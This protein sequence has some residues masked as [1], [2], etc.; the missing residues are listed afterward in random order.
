MRT[1]RRVVGL[2]LL[3]LCVTA[4]VVSLGAALEAP[5]RLRC[6]NGARPEKLV[7]VAAVGV[8][9]GMLHVLST[10]APEALAV[11]TFDRQPTTQ[12]L[13]TAAWQA[14]LSRLERPAPAPASVRK[15]E[16]AINVELTCD[17]QTLPKRTGAWAQGAQHPDLESVV[18][19]P[20]WWAL[21]GFVSGTL[22]DLDP[23]PRRALALLTELLRLEHPELWRD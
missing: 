15:W 16:G 3:V 17:G 4:G 12:P 22:A 1:R 13:D 10:I 23:R 9:H 18:R 20:S 14:L 2:I 5:V 6:P 7:I 8:G 11:A 21:S 19:R